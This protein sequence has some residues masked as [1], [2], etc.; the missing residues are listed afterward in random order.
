MAPIARFILADR[1]DDHLRHCD[2]AVHRR[3]EQQ[4]LDVERRQE[5]RVDQGDAD[6]RRDD[7]GERPNSR[8]AK[9]AGGSTS[10]RE[11]PDSRQQ[12]ASRQIHQHREQQQQPKPGLHQNSPMRYCSNP[13][14]NSLTSTDPSNAPS[15]ETRPP[16]SAS[17]QDGPEEGRQQPVLSEIARHRGDRRPGARDE[18]DRGDPCEN[19]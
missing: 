15:T 1:D 5:R 17:R 4:N 13:F 19:A 3:R 16:A 9:T 6:R 10:S 12:R 2:N 18:H 11:T 8:C 14:V 7:D